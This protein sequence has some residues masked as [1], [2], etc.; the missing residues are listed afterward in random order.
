MQFNPI[1]H[2]IALEDIF[3]YFGMG[4]GNRWYPS[5]RYHSFLFLVAWKL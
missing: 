5:S 1:W 4:L 3:L 2:P